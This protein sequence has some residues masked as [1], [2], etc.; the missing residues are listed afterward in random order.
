MA[1]SGG[2]DAGDMATRRRIISALVKQIEVGADQVN[3][4]YKVNPSPFAQAPTEPNVPPISTIG[5]DPC[6]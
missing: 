1:R 5:H 3:I 4:V 6:G 2:L